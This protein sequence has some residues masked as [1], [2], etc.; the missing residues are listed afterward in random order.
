VDVNAVAALPVDVFGD[1]GQQ[2]EMAERQDDRD[3]QV[4]IDAVEHAPHLGPVD[5]R[6]PHP[7]GFHPSSLDEVEHLVAVL[8]AHG[9]AQD[10]AQQPD[11]RTH[12]VRRLATD[13][14]PLDPDKWRDAVTVRVVAQRAAV[15]HDRTPL[16]ETR[17]VNWARRRL[18][19]VMLPGATIF[20]LLVCATSMFLARRGYGGSADSE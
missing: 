17:R 19:F 9:V 12:R 16:N 14:G 4:N 1:V 15:S 2:R 8:L 20:F 18:P 11:V 6:A 13:P 10:G 5:L 3:R 7:E